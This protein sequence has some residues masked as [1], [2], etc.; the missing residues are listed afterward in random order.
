MVKNM[1]MIEA[2]GA[3]APEPLTLSD[4]NSLWGS[5]VYI[6]V[7]KEV[8]QAERLRKCISFIPPARRVPRFMAKITQ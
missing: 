3:L 4:E 6:A 1:E 5:D 8:P 7:S 2:A